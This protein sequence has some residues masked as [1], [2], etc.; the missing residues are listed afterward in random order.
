MI[1]FEEIVKRYLLKKAPSTVIPVGI[2]IAE[3]KEKYNLDNVVKLASNENPF[4]VSPKALGAMTE[5]LQYG[6]LYPD[7][8]RDT[9]LKGKLAEKLNVLPENL[10]LTCGAAN[11]LACIGELFIGEGDECII[12][13]PAYPPY[14]YIV[15]KNNGTIIDIPCRKDDM[16]LDLD[17]ILK[18]VNEKTRLIFLCNPNNPTSTAYSCN[19]LSEFIE[20]LPRDVI[21]VVDEAYVDFTDDKDSFTMVPYLERFPNMIVVQTFSKLYGMAGVR[22]GYAIA[23]REIITYLNKTVAAR[24][25]STIAIEGGIA[26]L[27]DEEFRIKTITTVQKERKRLT[28]EMRSM[29]YRCFDS[30]SNFLYADLGVTPQDLYFLLL[31]YGVMIRGDFPMAR[32][33]IGTPSQNDLLLKAVK[34]LKLNDKL[35]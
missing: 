19:E 20:K 34:D 28:G 8:V 12:P 9:F 25:M 11:A 31:P 26:A 14:Y 18:A 35:P 17:A 27:D 23:C 29:G 3:A 2:S 30:K 22:L 21:V 4:G 15:Y 33:T 16:K 7:S 1:M 13:S 32:I 24:S 5:A 10:I 6:H